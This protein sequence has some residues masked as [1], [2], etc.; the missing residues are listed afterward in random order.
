MV[1]FSVKGSSLISAAM[2]GAERASAHR[3]VGGPDVHFRVGTHGTQVLLLVS[4]QVT[5]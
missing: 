3:E 4:L 1:K 2:V 5:C